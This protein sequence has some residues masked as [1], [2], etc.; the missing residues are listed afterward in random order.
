MLADRYRL[1]DE[2]GRGGM[3]VVYRATDTQLD[4]SIAVKLISRG[5][6]ARFETEAK[7]IAALNHPNIAHVYEFNQQDGLYYI[8]MEHVEGESLSQRLTQGT[9]PTEEAI[10]ST[11][12]L[13]EALSH[14]HGKGIIHRD[15]KPS[16]VLLSSE[17][18]P[19]LV[20][21]G[22]ARIDSDDG[23][24][25]RGGLGT[26]AYVAPEQARDGTL[27]DARS[28]LWSLAATLYQMVTG[29]SPRIIKFN[30]VPQSLQ[31]VLGKALEDAPDSR[32]QSADDF[33]DA[34][35]VV[36][37]SLVAHQP[38]TVPEGELA[39]GECPSCSTTNDSSRK[40]CKGCGA[41]L[42][43]A[44]LSCEQSIPVWE[45]FCGECGAGQEK[46]LEQ[47]RSS[48][49]EQRDEAEV[50]GRQFE[51]TRARELVTQIQ[52]ESD[53]RLQDHQGWATAFLDT[54]EEEEQKQQLHV[55]D[56]V[57]EAETHRAAHDHSSAVETLE[58][59]P[60]P[61]RTPELQDLLEQ[62]QSAKQESSGLLTTIHERTK[63]R[64]LEGLLELVERALELLPQREDLQK[65][66]GQLEA[67]KKKQ[68]EK[69]DTEAAQVY[70]DR[71]NA[72]RK[73]HDHDAAIIYY[74]EAIRLNPEYAVAYCNRGNAH[75]QLG[76]KSQAAADH[77][78]ARELG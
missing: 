32:Y 57:T 70:N 28:D 5:S 51:Y 1:E 55:A 77:Q 69:K 62:V 60:E 65:I 23:Q 19:K 34:L 61:L 12:S 66:K 37:D 26:P 2:L 30:N 46:S 76:N 31:D 48:M 64:E 29:R 40:F 44:C 15:I 17:R 4:R 45:R 6:V 42:H 18:V 16:N 27:A 75:S 68:S 41:A 25:T 43:L 63:S 9:I 53:P 72:H 21:F 24:L 11:V 10:G 3:G 13:C 59:I 36:L 38:R 74:T 50:L 73:K 54:L 14:A 47:R 33:R 71:G 56:L 52:S 35:Q 22:L 58:R 67:R 20:D 78:K 39:E 7:A 8:V 49:Q